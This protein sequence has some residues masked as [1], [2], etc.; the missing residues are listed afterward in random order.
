MNKKGDNQIL[1]IIF[2]LLV[3]VVVV[4]GVLQA[5]DRYTT[6]AGTQK[7]IAADELWLA[8]NALISLPG[9]SYAPYL[10]DLSAYVILLKPET[11]SR[12]AQLTV[13][14]PDENQYTREVRTINLPA[15]YTVDGFMENEARV[16]LQK[17]NREISLVRCS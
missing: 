3:V 2:E 17:E 12:T 14:I 4:A 6:S 5:A 10:Q 15:G 11:D 8:I 16:C 9:D 1:M 7:I 13:M